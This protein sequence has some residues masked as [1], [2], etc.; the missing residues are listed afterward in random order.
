MHRVVLALGLVAC[1]ASPQG[2]AV[3]FDPCEP[4][5]VASPGANAEQLASID[6]AIALWRA[7]GVTTVSRADAA[8]VSIVFRDAP[9]AM[10]GFYDSPHATVYVNTRIVEPGERAITIA[11]ELGHAFALVHIAADTR[12]SVMNP[13]NLTIAP[14][15]GDEAALVA[16]W[17][18][19]P[20]P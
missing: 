4:V 12:A 5:T 1:S 3:T 17:G 7:D 18:A 8:D 13:G 9:A 10:Y 16:A 15:A 6:D 20:A 19:C 11:H 2:P 14:N